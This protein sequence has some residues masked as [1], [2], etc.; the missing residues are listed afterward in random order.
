[1][2]K[3]QEA[4]GINLSDIYLINVVDKTRTFCNNIQ[5]MFK[6]GGFMESRCRIIDLL[7]TLFANELG[8][9]ITNY[10]MVA[11]IMME[12]GSPNGLTVS[13]LSNREFGDP[14]VVAAYKNPLDSFCDAATNSIDNKLTSPTSGLIAGQVIDFGTKYNKIIRNPDF[15]STVGSEEDVL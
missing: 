8:L 12:L 13:G 14:L 1:V 4:D 10:T 9:L 11:D 7:N 6:Y 15:V 3:R 5:E 2:Y